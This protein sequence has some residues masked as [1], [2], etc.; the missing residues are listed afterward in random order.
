[1]LTWVPN[2]HIQTKFHMWVV[3]NLTIIL[4]INEERYDLRKYVKSMYSVK[5]V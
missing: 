1:M 2:I 4:Q 3:N 5:N